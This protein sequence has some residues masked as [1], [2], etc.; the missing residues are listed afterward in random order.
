[1]NWAGLYWYPKNMALEVLWEVGMDEAKRL[2]RLR[3]V[4]LFQ[5]IPDAGLMSIARQL[6]ERSYETGAQIVKQ[7]EV[8]VGFYLIDEGKVEVEQ[9]GRV[10]TALG[11]GDF[12]G[13]LALMEDVPRTASVIARAPTRCLQLVRWHFRSILKENP[14]IAIRVLETAVRRLRRHEGDHATA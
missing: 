3:R 2:E 10:I 13:E 12:F 6:S 7:G 9:G 1:M 4:P 5:G 11:P 8:G 14:D